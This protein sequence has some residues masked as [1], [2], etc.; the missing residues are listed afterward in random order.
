M[1]FNEE[2]LLA[3][4]HFNGPCMVLAGPGS[5]KTTIIV[6]RI[7]FLTEKKKIP[8]EKILVITFTRTAAQEMQ[9]RY[10]IL[11][12][13][14]QGV[15]FGTFHSLFF[16]IIRYA[17]NYDISSILSED[18]RLRFL[19]EAAERTG[20]KKVFLDAKNANA[21]VFWKSL[22]MQQIDNQTFCFI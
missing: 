4:T 7:R 11:A 13:S 2:Q 5:G 21:E 20:A 10:R 12:G 8:P 9:E 22:G 19:K 18:E 14:G 17:Y 15:S 1:K 16:K 6:N 3:I